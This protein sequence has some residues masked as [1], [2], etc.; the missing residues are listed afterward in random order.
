[1]KFKIGN[2]VKVKGQTELHEVLGIMVDSDG[3]VYKVSSKE[4]DI[5]AKEI[6][7]GISFYREEELEGGIK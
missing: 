5:Q 3:V 4:V 2:K 7:N 1:M 6:V